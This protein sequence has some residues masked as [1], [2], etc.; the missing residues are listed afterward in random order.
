MSLDIQYI[1]AFQDHCWVAPSGGVLTELTRGKRRAEI[2]E[3]QP[4][5]KHQEEKNNDDG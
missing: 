5:R 3:E 4:P 2:E 1:F